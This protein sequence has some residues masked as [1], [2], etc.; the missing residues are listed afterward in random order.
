[1]RFTGVL[2]AAV[3][4]ALVGAVALNVLSRTFGLGLVGAN[5]AG[6]WLLPVLAFL[7]LP[8][9]IPKK[10]TW[11][12]D[13]SRVVTGFV[14]GVATLGLTG[15]ASRVGGIEPVLGIPVALRFGVVAVVCVF[16]L[17][18][19]LLNGRRHAV[20][21]LLGA[22]LA[23]L[24][25][26][27]LPVLVIAVFFLVMLAIRVPVALALLG[28]AALAPGPLSDAALS[29]TVVRGMSH[30]VLLA[31][32][33]FVLAAGLLV[34]G[35]VGQHILSAVRALCGQ[36]A[37]ALGEAN[38]WASLGFGGVS[39]SS[40]A[41]AATSARLL[42]PTM[43]RAGYR[44]ERACAISA[45]SAV[46][47]NIVPPSIALLLA[48][49]ATDQSVGTLWL[50]GLAAAPIFTGALLIAVRLTP[51]QSSAPEEKDPA[52]TDNTSSRRPLAALLPVALM[53]AALVLA[54]R[55]GLVTA[56]EA[57]CVAVLLALLF[58]AKE[59]GISAIGAALVEAARQSGRVG[60]LI[61]AAAPIAFLVATSGVNAADVIPTHSAAVALLVAVLLC[62]LVGTFLDAG[63]AIL[64][65]LPVL[66]PTLV[67]A[68]I[69]PAHGTLTLTLSLLIG[70]LTPPVGIL[71]LVVKE[72]G[73]ADGVYR[74][75]LPY[76]AA[77]LGALVVVLLVPLVS[78]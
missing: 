4:A 6:A 46:L 9:L 41:D 14:V 65:M 60:L 16:A 44:R 59:G 43:V 5:I 28:A 55:F 35:G 71:I 56:V 51:P 50:A 74:A 3:L 64:L 21:L 8:G 23:A 40:L 11:R 33:L 37:T 34:A 47:P 10:A 17:A 25:L 29:Q 1:M 57:G 63:A 67:A 68:G 27:S 53:G 15:A 24:P 12:G 32:P 36:R 2:A 78:G 52:P 75:A 49:A 72:V 19:G 58:A 61:G 13:V 77:L 18:I 69:G 45:A 73:G 31:V 66:I 26:P 76:L 54:L 38:V 22:G 48:A 7:A 39:A 62:L 30:S 70:G 42:V 20:T